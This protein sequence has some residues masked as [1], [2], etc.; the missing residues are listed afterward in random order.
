M[1]PPR[2]GGIVDDQKAAS[3]TDVFIVDNSD[4]D[5]KV[6]SRLR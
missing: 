4:S 1:R 5:W 2:Q 6:L 3:G